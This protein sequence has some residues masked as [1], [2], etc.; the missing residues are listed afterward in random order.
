M[1]HL[2]QVLLP[3]ADND[4]VPFEPAR[5]E[6]LKEELAREFSGVTA[7]LQAPAEG[8]WKPKE[9][10]V[11]RDDIVIFEVMVEE[12]DPHD[13][14]GWRTRLEHRFHQQKVVIRHWAVGVV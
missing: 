8:L 3:C 2:V 13:W 12:L 7:F 6:S 4:G 5:F 1:M 10:E 9:S 11:S 14:S